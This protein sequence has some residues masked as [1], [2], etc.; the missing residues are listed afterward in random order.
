MKIVLTGSTGF[1]GSHI[2]IQCCTT[3]SITS[4]IVLSR[5]ALAAS[6]LA[7]PDGDKISNIIV[8]DFTAYEDD[9]VREIEDAD[10]CIWYVPVACAWCGE[11]CEQD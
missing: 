2:L 9:V 5:R 7:Q 1:A 3:P 11:N 8:K 6:S 10:A 4:I